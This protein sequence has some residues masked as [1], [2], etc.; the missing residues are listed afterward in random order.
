MSPIGERAAKSQYQVHFVHYSVHRAVHAMKRQENGY[1]IALIYQWAFLLWK[2][3]QSTV[4]LIIP[5]QYWKNFYEQMLLTINCS[6]D[7]IYSTRKSSCGKPQEAY[8]PRHNQSGGTPVPAAG[9]Y[10]SYSLWVPLSRVPS[11]L[12]RTCGRIGVYPLERTWD[13]RLGRDLGPEA[14]VIPPC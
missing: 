13:Q 6:Q 5:S 9:G 11:P 7:Y 14:G 2:P 3:A 4:I 8:R 1:E 12:G 10:N